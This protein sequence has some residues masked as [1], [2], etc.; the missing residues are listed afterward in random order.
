MHHVNTD[1]DKKACNDLFGEYIFEQTLCELYYR[2][3]EICVLIKKEDDKWT[4]VKHENTTDV[5]GC[6]YRPQA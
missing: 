3:K 2:P 4:L 5:Y 6:V 1:I